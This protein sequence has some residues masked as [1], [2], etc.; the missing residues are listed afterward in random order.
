MPFLLPTTYDVP[1]VHY[2]INYIGNQEIA[3]IYRKNNVQTYL[4]ITQRLSGRC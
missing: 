4:E 1:A 2:K 3:A